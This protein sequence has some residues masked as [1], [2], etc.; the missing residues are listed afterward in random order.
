MRRALILTGLTLLLSL[1][2]AAN[3]AVRITKIYYDSPG[4]DTGSN[5]S[6]NAEY[7]TL[8]NNGNRSVNMT[9]WTIRDTSHHV[10]TF[11]S[12]RLGKGNTVTLHTGHGDDGR[13]NKYWD[14]GNYVWNNDG[15]TATLKNDR[16]R[17]KDSCHYPGGSPGWTNC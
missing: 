17:K 15:D 4:S 9:G 2:A 1:P 8:T 16:G 10:Y 14:M 3:A 11:D 5:S 6:L 13:R 7:I 12:F